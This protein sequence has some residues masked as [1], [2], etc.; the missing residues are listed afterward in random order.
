MPNSE[1][2]FIFVNLVYW[3]FQ[4]PF[5]VYSHVINTAKILDLF[6]PVQRFLVY[7]RSN[8]NNRS[9]LCYK[10]CIRYVIPVLSDKTNRLGKTKLLKIM[11]WS[12]SAYFM[13]SVPYYH[14]VNM[15]LPDF[16]HLDFRHFI[17]IEREFLCIFIFYIPINYLF[18]FICILQSFLM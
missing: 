12:I 8:Q 7:V 4:I 17:Y 9:C 5:L 11:L 13:V 6:K 15:D 1:N 16:I 14:C 3:K 10:N 18:L 2:T